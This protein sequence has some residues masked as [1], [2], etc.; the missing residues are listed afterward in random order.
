M[1]ALVRSAS[2][3]R[4]PEIATECGLDPRALVAEVGL[5]TRA[6]EDPDL[7][8]PAPAVG[9]LLELAAGR[10]SEPAFGLRMAESRRLS[11]LGPLALLVRDEPTLRDT[12]DAI[13]KHIRLHNEALTVGV[14][15]VGNLV[16]IR[17]ELDGGATAIR[18]GTE[19]VVGVTFR[20]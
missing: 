5:P 4:F 16:S 12:L 2:L 14:E 13:V 11:N 7:M 1:T 10:A 3:T 18:Q 17:E 20:L 19:L 9:R 6:L 8:I 15:Q